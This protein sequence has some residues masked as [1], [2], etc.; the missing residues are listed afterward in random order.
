[1]SKES[2]ISIGNIKDDT[3]IIREAKPD[4]EEGLVF[5]QF[6]DEASEGFFKSMLGIKTYEI[7]ADA[8]V[9]SNNEYS[10]ENVSMIEYKSKIVGM[11]S[12]YTYTEKQGYKKNILSQFPK[13]AKLRIMMFSV[14]GRILS[15]FLGPCGKE[16]YYVQAI[17]VNSQMRGKGLGQRL[18]KYSGEIA[19]KKGSK[20]LSLDVSSKNKKAINSYNKFGMETFSFWPNFLKLPPVF[21]RMV[22]EL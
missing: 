6:F 7:I 20:T 9:K 13:G 10:F 18:M 14:V 12:G 16:D 21:T 8:F 19:I 11:V 15:H 4:L 1:M 17:A 2:E 5:A 3:I 22:K